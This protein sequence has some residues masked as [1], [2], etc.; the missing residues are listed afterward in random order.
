MKGFRFNRVYIVFILFLFIFILCSI[1]LY[2][3]QM[4]PTVAVQ[5][6]IASSQ[7]EYTSQMK[8]DILDTNKQVLTNHNK[9]YIMVLD[10]QPFKLN[11]YE[12]TLEDLLALNFIMKSEKTD[13][14]YSDIMRSSGKFYYKISEESY[15]KVKGLK[16]TKG[17]YT[18]EYDELDLKEGWKPENFI[19]SIDI[20]SENLTGFESLVSSVVKENEYP[21]KSFLLDDKAVY[22][23]LDK[24]TTISNNN[25]QLTINRNWEEKIREV[26]ESDNYSFLKN[27][28]VVLLESST[29]K[30]RAMVQKDESAANINL[31]IGQLGYE[32]GSI[33]KIITE[34][35]ALDKGLITLE[36]VF[37][38]NGDICTKLGEAYAH[39]PLSVH[40]AL[41]VSCNDVFAKVGNS[42]GY[43]DLI[44]YTSKLGLYNK[45]LELSGEN[46]E[47]AEGVKPKE[48]DGISNFSI[49]QCLTV[50]PLQIAGAINS[51][52]NDGMY[53]KPYI[54]EAVLD[55]E[56]IV[57]EE[58]NTEEKRV[59][60]STTA[61]LV[62]S[63]M[64]DV[65]WYGTGYEAKVYDITEG[66]KTGTSTGQ[67]GTTNHGWFAG[68][69]NLNGTMYTMVVVAPD[70]GD[71]HPD[72][73]E[74]GGGNTGAPIFRDIINMLIN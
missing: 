68:Y 66:G 74:L 70:I 3:L 59:F 55:K 8:Y 43:N 36:T 25:I 14:N 12:E 58:L 64:T 50:T 52:T 6:Q 48:S 61:K 33:F 28:G 9:K 19:A 18:Y 63:N 73:R 29:G 57:I 34:A 16:N 65:I 5:G 15:N 13:F 1:R 20:E 41:L 47:E 17:I 49:G 24:D 32:P 37:N 46:R 54:I 2:F 23:E 44:D 11:N 62:Q 4:H 27:I 67:G 42:I 71:T 51:I 10:S 21:T 22:S 7:I 40:D 38:C 56:N 45:V 31:G 26:L 39:G 30:V 60:N 53:V 35:I 69:F 72:G